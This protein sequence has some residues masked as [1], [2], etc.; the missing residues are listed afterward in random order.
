MS[1]KVAEAITLF[2]QEP[3]VGT[4]PIVYNKLMAVVTPEAFAP[5]L[6]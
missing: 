3:C 2:W 1:G 5:A 4:P 6:E